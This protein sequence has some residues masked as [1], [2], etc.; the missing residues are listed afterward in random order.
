MIAAEKAGIIKKGTPVIIGENNPETRP[1]FEAKAKEMQ[2]PITF[3]EDNPEILSAEPTEEGGM[4]YMTQHAGELI[5]DLGGIYQQKNMN[6]VLYVLKVLDDLGFL[7]PLPN[8]CYELLNG[9]TKGE[10]ALY[11]QQKQ[12]WELTM[13]HIMNSLLPNSD[14]N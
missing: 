4:R 2:A 8:E 1:V 13:S 9:A 7:S 12:D 3:A 11:S 10:E 6:T 14:L 5:G